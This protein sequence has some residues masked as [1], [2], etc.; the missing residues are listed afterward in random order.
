MPNPFRHQY[1]ANPSRDR[2][3]LIVLIVSTVFIGGFLFYSLLI[4]TRYETRE[5]SPFTEENDWGGDL[6]ERLGYDAIELPAQLAS[7]VKES[8][9]VSRVM[10]EPEPLNY[11]LGEV[12]DRPFRFFNYVGYTSV[13]EDVTVDEILAAPDKN[14]ARQ[15]A[16]KGELLSLEPKSL[17]LPA[18]LEEV[19][20]GVLKLAPAEGETEPRFVYFHCVEE[21][22]RVRVGDVAQIFGVFFKSFT[23]PVAGEADVGLQ[24]GPF[25]IARRL[26]RSYYYMNVSEI[27]PN[28]VRRARDTD[29]IQ[30][31]IVEEEPWF[32]VASW[33]KNQDPDKIR[34]EYVEDDDI[35]DVYTF[36]SAHRGKVQKFRGKLIALEKVP[37]ED[38]PAGIDAY[39]DGIVHTLDNVTV[40]LRFIHKPEGVSRSDFVAVRAVFLKLHRY[41]SKA[42]TSPK[43]PLLVGVSIDRVEFRDET[44]Q[45]ISVVVAGA[46]VLLVLVFAV[47]LALGRRSARAFEDAYWERK[48][49]RAQKVLASSPPPTA[50]RGEAGPPS[51]AAA[52]EADEDRTEDA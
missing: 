46:A 8:S 10:V 21:P 4:S 36:P 20:E 39:Y 45:T 7:Q 32:H 26:K 37:L 11:L 3:T 18:P 12:A 25:M 47:S 17:E 35:V 42:D 14:R 52:P 6:S 43:V 38:N 5:E 23:F 13:P 2:R 9:E 1:K 31:M 48:R 50:A 33:V 16:V 44:L 28:V 34:E 15:F 49:N 30:M 22:S 51:D 41:E 40:R 19:W 24:N 27:D 29:D